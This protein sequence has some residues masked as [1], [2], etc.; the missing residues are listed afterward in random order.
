MPFLVHNEDNLHIDELI[1]H[2]NQVVKFA[3]SYS[4]YV[5][6]LDK[7][8]VVM[9]NDP[10]EYHDLK[11]LSAFELLHDGFSVETEYILQ[12]AINLHYP[13][14]KTYKLCIS[15]CEVQFP[16]TPFKVIHDVYLK[17]TIVDEKTIMDEL[18]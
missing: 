7:C 12:F 16:E 10:C 5:V 1:G 4:K 14:G 9:V 6:L 3:G 18:D 8:P 11:L 15:N 13:D 2:L 17:T